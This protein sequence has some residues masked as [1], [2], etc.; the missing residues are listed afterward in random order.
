MSAMGTLLFRLVPVKM[1]KVETSRRENLEG[2]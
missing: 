2:T 1:A